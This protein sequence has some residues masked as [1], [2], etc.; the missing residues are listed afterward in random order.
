MDQN[1]YNPPFNNT[2]SHSFQ[3][4]QPRK[5]EP[6]PFKIQP[7]NTQ[8]IVTPL[9]INQEYLNKTGEEFQKI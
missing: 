9:Q 6:S 1:E 8:T 3:S 4:P 5:T 2:Y 7:N